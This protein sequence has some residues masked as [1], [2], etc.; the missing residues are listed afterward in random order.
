MGFQDLP[1]INAVLNALTTGA[2]VA[3]YVLIRS[4]RRLAHRRCMIT[5]VITSAMFLTGYLVYHAHAGHTTFKNPAW[6]RPSYLVLLLSHTMMAA[7][8]VPLVFVTLTYALRGRFDRHKTIARWTWPLWV[9]VSFT[10]VLIY[11]VLYWIFPQV[12]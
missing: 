7:V 12:R 1:A 2:L 9:Y 6:F 10:G 8:I 11:L 3:G 5:G 4:G